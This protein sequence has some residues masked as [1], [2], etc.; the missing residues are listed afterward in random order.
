M[1][2]LRDDGGHGSG[3]SIRKGFLVT[4]KHVIEGAKKP[5]FASKSKN[6]PLRTALYGGGEEKE[7]HESAA[8][9]VLA[10]H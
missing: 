4:N 6:S 1:P 7:L 5:Q 8:R 2:I 9:L 10:P 3:V